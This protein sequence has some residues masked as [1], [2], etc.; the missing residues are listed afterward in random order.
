MTGKM[1]LICLIGALA[2]AILIMILGFGP[3]RTWGTWGI[4]V[5]SVPFLDLRVIT[6]GAE[7]WAQGY[8]PMYWNPGDTL[9]RLLNYPRVWQLTFRLGIDQTDTM[10]I[11]I[12]IIILFVVGLLIFTGEYDNLTAL[13]IFLLVCSPAIMFA[14]ERGN[15]DLLIFFLVS[16]SLALEHSCPL[17]ALSVTFVVSVLKLYPVFGVAQYFRLPKR[18]F[19][20]YIGGLGIAFLVYCMLTFNDVRQVAIA[21]AR[22]WSWSYG[23][24][25]IPI[26]LE[27]MYQNTWMENNL[28][29]A[30]ITIG[31]MGFVVTIIIGLAHFSANS[32]DSEFHLDAFR[33]GAAIYIG[34]FILG[35]NYDYRLIFLIL[36]LPQIVSW[37]RLKNSSYRLISKLTLFSIF[38]LCWAEMLTKFIDYR[39]TLAFKVL[40]SWAALWL[41]TY[42]LIA[43]TPNW[44]R[45]Q[46]K[47]ALPLLAGHHFTEAKKS[48]Q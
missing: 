5:V 45:N 1:T 41:L 12:G 48:T 43:C 21:T 30:L 24:N 28:L 13:L 23:I 2:V 9:G 33:A 10:A 4:T 36:T 46:V 47:H 14:I 39:I 38:G 3:D 8:D 17:L 25:V 29:V 40:A 22:D 6:G 42:L 27:R 20:N 31:A 16:V 26:Y 7:S 32:Q 18:V 35:N 44:F 37:I 19:W 34:T 11:G 15:V